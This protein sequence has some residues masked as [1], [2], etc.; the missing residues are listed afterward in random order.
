MS[1]I[2]S[3]RSP[4]V[5]VRDS[6]MAGRG[7]HAIADIAKGE[8]VAIKAGHIVDAAEEARLREEVGDYALQIEDDWYLA[9]RTIPEIEETA[10]FMNHSCDAN[11]GFTGQV[12][13]TALRDIA[14]GEELCHDYSMMRGDSYRLE[15]CRCGS[16]LCRGTVTGDDWRLPEL[17]QR[18]GDRF[19]AYLLR[20]IKAAG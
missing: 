16:P 9:P 3:M 20:R 8:L 1:G 14:A 11:I 13:Y 4:K 12:V 17:Q 15:G 7:C 5:E 2:R 10:V 18:Y 19:M 6:E